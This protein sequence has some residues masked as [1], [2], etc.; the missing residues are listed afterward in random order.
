MNLTSTKR[1]YE[2][3]G[4][5]DAF[6]AVLSRRGYSHNRWDPVEF[7]EN[8]RSEIN[9]ILKYVDHLDLPFQRKRALDFGTGVGRL[10]QALAEHFDSVV[11]V[12]IAESMVQKAR[13]YN[14]HGDRVEYLVNTTDDLKI[15]ESNSFDFVYSNITLQH[16]P[17]GSAANYIH[18]FF[19]LLKPGG[20]AI[21]QIPSGKPYKAGSLGALLY[22]IRRRHLRQIWK[23]IRGRRPVEIHYIAVEQ[24][25][26]IIQ[27]SGGQ[28]VDLLDLV[29]LGLGHKRGKNFR[30]C[31]TN[32]GISR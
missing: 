9:E 11:G 14:R 31:A 24:V 6:Y 30:Y 17:P 22:T 10:S 18:E 3:F 13:E 16:I 26:Q 32:N 19:R 2:E 7:F 21:F 1:T 8:G 20:V 5:N 29:D 15:L 25:K 12:D 23:I 28:L 27:E 4:R